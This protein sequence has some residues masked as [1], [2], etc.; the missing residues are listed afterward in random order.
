MQPPNMNRRLH[1]AHASPKDDRLLCRDH[2]RKIYGRYL[3]TFFDLYLKNEEFRQLFE[4]SKGFCLPHFGDLIET[5]EN[6]LNDTQKKE[7]YPKAFALMQENMERLQKEV[8]WFVEKMIT[9]IKIRTGEIPQTV[10]SAA[11]RN[12]PAAI[13][14]MKCSGQSCKLR[15]FGF[16][17][18]FQ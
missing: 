11:C 16:M 14:Q 9:A 13:R 1:L 3:D 5:A 12:V 4:E 10:F 18:N 7:F 6:K 8:S 15:S 17:E 2:F